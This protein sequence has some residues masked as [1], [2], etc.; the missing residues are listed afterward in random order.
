MFH[1]VYNPIAG[2]GK[3]KHYRE[4]LEKSLISKGVEHRF[5]ETH[6]HGEAVD[7]VRRLSEHGNDIDIISMG[8]DGTLHEV[9]NGFVDPARVRLG[10]IPCGSGNDFAATA[11][12]PQAMDAAMNLI[13]D[14]QARFTD[15]MTCSGVRGMNAIGTG[16]DV[17]ILRRYNRMKLLKSSAAY[18]ASLII[19]VLT[20]KFYQFRECR[21]GEEIPHSALIACAGNGQCFGG[22]IYI[23]PEAKI[24]DGLLDIVIVDN[25]RKREIPGA[26]VQLMKK[27]V[28]QIEATRFHRDTALR[29]ESDAPMP[30]QIDGEIYED[31]P[32]DVQVV[33][34]V[35]RV[36]R[37]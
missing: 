27:R 23:C 26:F 6:T 33:H 36:Y 10:I 15:F 18:L 35:L 14:G 21:G 1:I 19:T 32:F 13:L 31:L 11:G 16:I 30:I 8:G 3:S 4:T 37:P 24:D 17:D 5:Y 25:L 29:V 9:L 20:F 22:G 12:I 7:I 2:K 34:N 28:L